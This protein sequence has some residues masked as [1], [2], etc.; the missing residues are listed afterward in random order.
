MTKVKLQSV[1]QT[2]KAC[3]FSISFEG[4]SFSEFEK[5]ISRHKEAYSKDLN[6]IL[7]AIK[8]MLSVSGFLERYHH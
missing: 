2:E 4:E 6:I 5:F 7:A 8:R 3:L 1:A